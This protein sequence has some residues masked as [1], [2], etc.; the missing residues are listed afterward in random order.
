MTSPIT[1]VIQLAFIVNNLEAGIEHYR[2]IF[3]LTTWEVYTIAPPSL[4]HLRYHGM[5]VEFSMRQA[6][7]LSEDGMQYELIQPLT[8]RVFTTIF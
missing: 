2:Q 4:K 8:G 7:A 5:P 3:G 1:K 6:V